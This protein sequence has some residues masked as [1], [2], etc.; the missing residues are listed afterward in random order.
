MQKY[1]LGLKKWRQK[2]ILVILIRRAFSPRVQVYDMKIFWSKGSKTESEMCECFSVRLIF[3][4]RGRFWIFPAITFRERHPSIII[5]ES[6]D[7]SFGRIIRV[8]SL[9]KKGK[10][11]KN[12][13]VFFAEIHFDAF[14]KW[15][16]C[17]FWYLAPKC[18][19]DDASKVENPS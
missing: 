11:T 6:F 13:F 5:S 3:Q 15:K 9:Q 7:L 14:S 2:G 12:R 18:N 19:R 1:R 8:S 17:F 10:E 16:L 4:G